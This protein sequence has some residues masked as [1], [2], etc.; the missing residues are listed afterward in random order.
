VEVGLRGDAFGR[1]G[2]RRLVGGAALVGAGLLDPARWEDALGTAAAFEG[3]RAPPGALT[4]WSVRYP[5]G[6]DPFAGV[7]PRFPDAPPFV[8]LGQA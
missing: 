7:H 1:Y 3:L 2:V 5:D 8:P 4:L 6:L